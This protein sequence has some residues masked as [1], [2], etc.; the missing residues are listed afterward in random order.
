M[1]TALVVGVDGSTSAKRAAQV[2]G[3][4]ALRRGTCRALV[5]HAPCPLMVIP[6]GRRR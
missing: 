3:E 2:A 5:D 1:R 4:L 6:A